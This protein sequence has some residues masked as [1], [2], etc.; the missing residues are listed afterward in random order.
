MIIFQ[1]ELKRNFKSFAIW[2]I[3]M[4]VMFIYMAYMYPAMANP[5]Q[6]ESF[7][8][9]MKSFSDGFLKAFNIDIMMNLSDV[10]SFF[11]GEAYVFW[12]LFG[13]IYAMILAS[14]ILS[15]EESDKT[16][17]FLLSKPV[18]RNTV[19]TSKL[20]N[21]LFYIFSFNFVLSLG[22]YI[23]C[24]IVK[25]DEFS[26][27]IFIL[28]CVGA[29]L[30][31]LMFAAVG[32]FISVFIVKAKS[33]IP[34][35]IGVVLGT[36][37]LNAL[38]GMTEKTENFKYL[39]PFKYVDAR[40]ILVDKSLNPLYLSIIFIVVVISIILSYVFYNRKDIRN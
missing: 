19:V 13:S 37:F 3:L 11:A 35:S 18:K 36:Y 9:M 38:A 33:I 16:A 4:L 22:S 31:Q 39:T 32:F 12:L 20:L 23:S 2:T 24:E 34:V 5:E 17:E 40:D 21:V 27:D 14:G 26:R 29:F 28:L 8:N 25:R 7:K 6:A 15:K 1:R 30:V 10:T